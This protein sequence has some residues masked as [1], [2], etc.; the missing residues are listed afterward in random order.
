M[1]ISPAVLRCA[2]LVVGCLGLLL[3]GMAITFNAYQLALKQFFSLSQ[4]Q[5]ED[6]ASLGYVGVQLG[7][8]PGWTYEK[9]GIR[10]NLVIG[11]VLGTGGYLFIFS[12]T[13]LADFYGKNHWLLAMYFFFVGLGG[14]FTGLTSMTPNL[15]NFHENHG[16][17]IIG[18]LD[19]AFSL[20]STLSAATYAAAFINGH[21]NGDEAKQNI[22]GY[23]I[24]LASASLVINVLCIIFV[25]VVPL[26]ENAGKTPMSEVYSSKEFRY[27]EL[28]VISDAEDESDLEYA[29]GE[30]PSENQGQGQSEGDTDRRI[31]GNDSREAVTMAS[32]KTFPAI[33]KDWDFHFILW[34]FMFC[35]T[36][37][38]MVV[39]NITVIVKAAN[40]AS[41]AAIF[42]V[43]SPVVTTLTK[44]TMG[45][46]SDALIAKISR[47]SM[48]LVIIVI[49]TVTLIVCCV[50]PEEFASLV[51]LTLSAAVANGTIYCLT[52]LLLV[53][54]FGLKHF[55]VNWGFTMMFSSFATVGVQKGFGKLYDYYGYTAKTGET[56]CYGS[57]C[58]QLSLIIAAVL[59]GCAV[60][61]N[62]AIVQRRK[63][64]ET[65]RREA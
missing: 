26:S 34:V 63:R 9:I 1:A 65:I 29:Q 42:P 61:F 43:L 7:L 62:V 11:L 33:L 5:T 60:L 59:S 6:I 2:A 52:P 16:G 64:M 25:R 17:K 23:F 49:Q 40:F 8:L 12:S 24:M 55:G 31:N 36:L 46:V 37:Q 4:S 38:F 10:W 15:G 22:S 48:L 3:Q 27:H 18:L 14:V 58:F 39:N 41:Q 57:K 30:L 21:T 20:G 44:F 51:A 54:H 56:L 13:Y 45:V 19:S 35:T 28:E 50:I 32:E 47:D 53:E